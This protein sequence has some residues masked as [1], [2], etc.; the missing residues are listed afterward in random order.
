I[1]DKPGTYTVTATE[2]T[3]GCT[4]Q[5]TA[6][7][8]AH[9]RIDIT[10][11][12]NKAAI[13]ANDIYTLP[14]PSVDPTLVATYQWF[15]GSVDPASP[16]GLPNQTWDVNTD[17]T[18]TLQ[19]TDNNGCIEMTTFRLTVMDIPV[20][21]LGA[22]KATC[23]GIPITL[24]SNKSFPLYKWDNMDN[25]TQ[26]I[27]NKQSVEVETAGNYQLQTWLSNGCTHSETI[28]VVVHP[29]PVFALTLEKDSVCTGEDFLLSISNPSG[30]IAFE[31]NTGETGS[32]TI[33]LTQPGTYTV[34][35]Y[36][37]NGCFS[38]ASAQL[39]AYTPVLNNIEDMAICADE[40]ATLPTYDRIPIYNWYYDDNSTLAGNQDNPTQV[41][42][43]GTYRLVGTDDN[44]CTI[45]ASMQLTVHPLPI[46]DLGGDRVKC[47]GDTL[48]LFTPVNYREY[49]WNG[50]TSEE[51]N[52]M[53]LNTPG[54]QI[55]SLTVTDD[56]GCQGSDQINIRVN[57]LP[58]VTLGTDILVCPGTTSTLT[59]ITNAPNIV[60]STRETTQSIDVRHGTFR[61]T[62]TDLNGCQNRDTIRVNWRQSPQPELGPNMMICPLDELTLDAGEYTAYQWQNGSTDRTIRAEIADTMNMVIVTDEYGC[63]GWDT[64][65]VYHEALPEYHL[66]NDTL[67]CANEQLMLDA[68]TEYPFYLW[69]DGSIEQTREITREGTYWVRV[70]DGCV[71]GS[72]TLTV[73]FHPMPYI[74]TLDTMIYAQ[75]SVIAGGGTLPF[76]YSLNQG[77]YQKEPVFKHLEN[78]IYEVWVKDAN[79]CM[80]AD[81]VEINSVLDLDIP[82]YLTP[83]GDGIND[84]WRI[85]GM[86]RF[87]DAEINI[88]DRYGKLIVKIKGDSPGWDGRFMGKPV[89]SDDY[90]FVVYLNH[91]NKTIKG[92]ITLKR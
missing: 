57:P 77:N 32:P 90:W 68:G 85:G 48:A 34:R 50:I 79:N 81:T 18:Y 66:G 54:D 72:D 70:T 41:N 86:E 13:C 42:T 61:V 11:T 38:D 75:I 10:L 22:D 71:W 2:N 30:L 64:K 31:W 21:D 14:T 20:F 36:D 52:Y 83:N 19:V 43:A 45:T 49:Q 82:G 15:Q 76:H 78:G 88:L 55:I 63:T 60:W 12:P 73:T 53:P 26:V 56:N 91:I 29:N 1:V 69:E 9:P 3:H 44:G 27:P 35:G 6:I 4:N 92:N 25:P 80:T 40:T 23:E 51:L 89:P 7:V 5:A 8:Q 16:Q 33:T 58:T 87:P 24:S 28:E 74:E 62:A 39:N 47:V 67:L 59:A 46:I 17:D 65:V 37:A 84:V